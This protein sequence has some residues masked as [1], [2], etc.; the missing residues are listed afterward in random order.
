MRENIDF[1]TIR[2]LIVS[3]FGDEFVVRDDAG[4]VASPS[5][6]EHVPSG[7]GFRYI[8]GGQFLMGFSDKEE[9][10]ARAIADPFPSNISEMRPVH[11]VT[12]PP[13]LISE[14]PVLTS[15]IRGEESSLAAYVSYEEAMA[16]GE[17][18]GMTLPKEAQWEYACRAGSN[19]LFTWGDHLPDDEE[20]EDWLTL[21]FGQGYGKANAFGLYGLF[22]GE[23]CVDLFTE[24][25][26]S[27]VA[28]DNK[29]GVR[30]VRGGGAYFW[31]WQDEEWVWCMSA[32]RLPATD[33]P[34]GECGFRL[35]RNI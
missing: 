20:L 31:P 35:V 26:D 14:R 8:P 7:L 22:V 15:E 24:S 13:F 10:A 28:L 21:D 9:L 1:D 34:E 12:V 29:N 30:V 27:S 16:Y 23:W 3:T 19:T 4:A 11:Q 6:F 2:R 25:Y 32:M 5:A 18:F 17:Q 33:L